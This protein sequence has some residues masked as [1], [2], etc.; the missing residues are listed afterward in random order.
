MENVLFDLYIAETEIRENYAVFHSD[1]IRRQLLLHSV[2]EKHRISE[3]K[4]DTSLVW[5]NA[6]LDRYLKINEKLT[7][8]YTLLIE[9]LQAEVQEINRPPQNILSFKEMGLKDFTTPI[10]TFH[11]LNHD[12]DSIRQDTIQKKYI[13]L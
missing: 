10:Y 4:F 9:N 3:Q 13:F 12:T 7:A 11:I 8:R 1:S 6:H 2:F 5:Y